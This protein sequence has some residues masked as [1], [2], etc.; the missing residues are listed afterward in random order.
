LTGVIETPVPVPVTTESAIQGLVAI[1]EIVHAFLTADRPQEVYQFALERVSPLVGATFASVYVLDPESDVMRLSAAY[2]WPERFRPFLGEMRVRVGLG[3]SGEAVSEQ[4]PIQVPDVFADDSL[5]DWQE[6]AREL[7]F[8]ALVALPLQSGSRVLGAVTFYYAQAG[9]FNTDEDGLLRIVADQMAATAEKAAL[10]DE[11][12]RAN[13]ALME[14]HAE[15][16]K[17]YVAAVEARRLKDEFLSNMSHELRTPLTAVLGYAYLLQEGLNGPLTDAQRGTLIHLTASSERLLALVE[18][19]LELTTLKR[20]EFR[21]ALDEFDPRE[22]LNDAIGSARSK[23]EGIALTVAA[24]E[25]EMPPMRSDRK[26]VT[27]I[28]GN[29]LANA[30]KFTPHGEVRAE[31]EL[32]PGRVRFVV[33]DTGIGIPAESQQLVFEEFRQ[34]DG[35]FTREHGGS[36]LGLA[37]SRQL[38]RLLGGDVHLHSAPEQGSSFTVDLPLTYAPSPLTP[39]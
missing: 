4:R 29:L 22:V 37:L 34:A 13:A 17:Q 27:K 14:N 19:L 30:F 39:A 3:P 10:I 7:G 28:L 9:H 6:V 2:N 25:G 5:R 20:G 15:L 11:L 35:S 24:P 18:D 36:G 26:K 8:R 32:R 38:A 16:E 21:I 1:R 23:P 31:I 33:S 12:R